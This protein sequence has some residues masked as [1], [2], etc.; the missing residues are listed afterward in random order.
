[1]ARKIQVTVPLD[2]A[3]H[4]ANHQL[5]ERFVRYILLKLVVLPNNALIEVSVHDPSM[6]LPQCTIVVFISNQLFRNLRGIYIGTKGYIRY[7]VASA[8]FLRLY[9]PF[10]VF[11]QP[12]MPF[13]INMFLPGVC[14]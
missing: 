14:K 12:M 2:A 7:Y 8:H 13:L 5:L 1:M 10:T 3:K 4:P 11:A 9:T 6:L